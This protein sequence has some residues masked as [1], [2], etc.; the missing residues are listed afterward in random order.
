MYVP[1]LKAFSYQQST[2]S[3]AYKP[4]SQIFELSLAGDESAPSSEAYEIL[5]LAA[6]SLEGL[7]RIGGEYISAICS[8]RLNNEDTK[9]WLAG[10]SVVYRRNVLSLYVHLAYDSEER[11]FWS[12][13]FL[14]DS[15]G[16]VPVSLMREEW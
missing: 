9:H 7:T 13:E 5:S 4:G 1:D 15:G 16:Y 3:W 12:V 11:G 8:V 10:A 14:E 6:D 2:N